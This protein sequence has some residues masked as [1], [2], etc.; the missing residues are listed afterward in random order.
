MMKLYCEM[1]EIFSF[2]DKKTLTKAQSEEILG[3]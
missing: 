1:R 2:V 3:I